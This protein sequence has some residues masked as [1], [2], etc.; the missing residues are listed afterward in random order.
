MLANDKSCKTM[1]EILSNYEKISGQAVNLRK[2]AISFGSRVKPQVKTRMRHI[3]GIHNEGG[4]GKYLGLPEEIKRKKAEM[5]E[6][7][8]EK[9]K[10]K[11]HGWSKKFL[12]AGGKEVLLKSVAL[13]L[14]V[15]SMNI[16]KFPKSIC[17]E[18]NRIIAKF[19]WSNGEEKR[20]MHWFAWKRMV[21]SKKEG[22]MGFRDFENFNQALL[23]K[24]VWRILQTPDCLMTRMLKHRYFGDSNIL[25]ATI[26]PKASFVWKSL[27]HGRDLL[28]QGLRYIVGNSL[29]IS[30][31][32]DLWLP[33]H[34]PRPPK[35]R[36]IDSADCWLSDWIQQGQ[37][38]NEATIRE[39]VT[40]EDA[41]LIL[42]LKLCTSAS[43]DILGWHY[44]QDGNYSVKSA[45]WLANQLNWNHTIQAPPGNTDIKAKVWK[46]KT[47]PK[48]KHFLWKLLSEALATGDNLRRRHINNHSLCYRCCQEEETTQ[49]LFFDCFFAQQVWRALGIPHQI[50][51]TMGTDIN[52]RMETILS[53]ILAKEH[54]Q[55]FHLA[56]WIIWR[57][58]K[59]RNKLVFQQKNTSV[60]RICR[61]NTTSRRWKRPPTGWVKCNYDG[62]FNHHTQQSKAGWIIRDA[63]G[64]FKGAGQAIGNQTTSA[65]ENELQAVIIAM[66]HLWSQG[67]RKVIFEGDNKQVESLMNNRNL[68]FRSYNW[69]RKAMF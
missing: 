67:Y 29:Q 8:I 61:S 64:V 63:S 15:Y 33:L 26:K 38:W 57:L 36:N 30:T 18:I 52:T 62:S 28:K 47:A 66:Q 32:K 44:T 55:F 20:G 60:N 49:H 13:A 35:A 9:V 54:P 51:T 41:D 37:V 31:W 22:G 48:I 53:S 24:Q 19:W 1:K 25:H 50:L 34:P 43:Q 12:S 6:Y 16:F 2:S 4:H 42:S 68:N 10:E 17:E 11:T 56:I 39:K 69:I 5:F 14:P 46:L 23:G 59:S 3:L 45:Y 21:M 7:I 58:W 40:E 27:L 65:L